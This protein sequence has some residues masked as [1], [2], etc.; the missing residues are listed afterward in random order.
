[1]L[2][3][4]EILESGLLHLVGFRSCHCLTGRET[5]TQSKQLLRSSGIGKLAPENVRLTLAFPGGI[6]VV[7]IANESIQRGD[8]VGAGTLPA[9]SN[10]QATS[11]DGITVILTQTG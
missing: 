3:C 2:I 10:L 4:H 9:P 1:M 5:M 11:P 6:I 7:C 8:V